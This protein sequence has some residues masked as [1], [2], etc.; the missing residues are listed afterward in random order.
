MLRLLFISQDP[1]Y[2]K[3]IINRLIIPQVY[4]HF[5]GFIKYSSVSYLS[6]V[7][8]A[9]MPN[10]ALPDNIFAVAM[11]EKIKN[12]AKSNKN[13]DHIE[14]IKNIRGKPE[15]LLYNSEMI[16]D[17]HSNLNAEHLEE[18]M[19]ICGIQYDD[20]WKS[21]T[22]FIDGIL[23]KNRNA[24]AHGNLNE[25]DDATVEECLSNVIEIIE[26]YRVKIG[27]KLL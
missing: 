20:Y 22:L 2:E 24:I 1:Q 21:K 25:V 11:R 8:E 5:E 23:L 13:K 14:L 3:K 4:S 27:E 10:E 12:L 6:Y 15:E 17:T 7:K 18:I 9:Y 19:A 16:I 26:R